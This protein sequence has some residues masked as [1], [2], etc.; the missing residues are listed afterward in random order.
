MKLKKTCNYWSC[1]HTRPGGRWR[2]SW[3]WRRDEARR[4]EAGQGGVR[5]SV[6][7]EVWVATTNASNT[8]DWGRRATVNF[9]NYPWIKGRV[10]LSSKRKKAHICQT[11]NVWLNPIC[12][13]PFPA[14]SWVKWRFIP[15]FNW[16]SRKS[17]HHR[18]RCYKHRCRPLVMFKIIN[19]GRGESAAFFFIWR[20]CTSQSKLVHLKNPASFQD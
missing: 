5:M 19:F 10:G 2:W 11:V 13:H 8:T 17:N 6:M 3:S 15:A 1:A 4:G 12:L 18:N 20:R 14:A 16:D 9:L 7:D